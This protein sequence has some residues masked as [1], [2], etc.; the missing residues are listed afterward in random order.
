MK[1]T[2]RL[3]F[4]SINILFV[5]LPPSDFT[6]HPLMLPNQNTLALGGGALSKARQAG[7]LAMLVNTLEA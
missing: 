1:K 4:L 6:C 3:L 5:G 7:M 2:Y